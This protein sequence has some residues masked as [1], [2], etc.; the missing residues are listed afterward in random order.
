MVTEWGLQTLYKQVYVL[1]TFFVYAPEQSVQVVSGGLDA[2]RVFL[3]NQ[4]WILDIIDKVCDELIG[5]FLYDI[6][7]FLEGGNLPTIDLLNQKLHE[8]RT[9]MFT[10]QKCLKLCYILRLWFHPLIS[11]TLI[12]I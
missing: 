1:P 6:I 11:T 7:D 8:G 3:L 10:L 4:V 2:E 12:Y 5:I 9:I